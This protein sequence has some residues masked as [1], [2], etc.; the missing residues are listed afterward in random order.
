M[1]TSKELK[2]ILKNGIKIKDDGIKLEYTKDDKLKILDFVSTNNLRDSFK[3][4]L[5]KLILWVTTNQT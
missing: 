5:N 4:V 3:K 1:K 2:E